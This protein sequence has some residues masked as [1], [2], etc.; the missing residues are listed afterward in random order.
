VLSLEPTRHPVISQ[1]WLVPA[2]LLCV[3]V[4]WGSTYLGIAFMVQSIPPLLGNAV[5]MLTAGL[6][7]Y[8][9]LRRHGERRPT[10][11]QWRNGAAVGTLLFVGGLGQVSIAESIGIGSGVAATAIAMT[12]V[13]ASLVSGLFGSWPRR[14]QWIG[15]GLG[16]AGVT[17][18]SLEGDFQAEPLGFVLV[19]VAPILWSFGSVWSNHI[20][21]PVSNMRAALFMIG[22]GVS[23]TI[24]GTLRGE[25]IPTE[26][27]A[28]SVIALIYLISFGSLLAFSAY[29]FLLRTVS[30]SLATSYAYVNPI[31]AVILGVWLGGETLTGSA[32]IALPLIVVAVALIARG[33]R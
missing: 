27:S 25:M 22:G 29:A 6:I 24:A 31:V 4:V 26:S 21:L 28:T 14:L 30:A 8:V 13:W 33:S 32:F 23:L 11:R 2:A 9:T 17:V 12:P 18:L 5:R 16:V 1:R 10:A 19:L 20:D 15:L 7:L 3:Y